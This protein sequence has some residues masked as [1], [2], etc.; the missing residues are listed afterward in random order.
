MKLAV[1]TTV[2]TLFLSMALLS[3]PM[4]IS[5]QKSTPQVNTKGTVLPTGKE[6]VSISTITGQQPQVK[7]NNSKL[8]SGKMSPTQG[9]PQKVTGTSK[10][11]APT[12]TTTAPVTTTVT[13]PAVDD[14]A[15]FWIGKDA[16]HKS[17]FEYVYNKNNTDTKTNHTKASVDEYLDLYVNFR[18]KVKEAEELGMDTIG[19]I[20][21]ELETY[22][23]QL[24][25]SY[26]FD[27][28]VN[29]KLLVEAYERMKTEVKASHILVKINE[30]GLPADTLEAWRKIMD[31][32]KKLVKGEDFATLAK[33]N[34]DDPS[35]QQNGGDIGYF[36]ALQTVYPF[37][38]VAYNTPV[39]QISMPVRTKFG[40]HLVKVT[41]SRPAQGEITVAHILIKTPKDATP[42]QLETAKKK[43][44]EAY[45]KAASGTPFEQLVAIYSEDKSTKAKNGELPPFGT[46][47]MV[48]EF[49][50]AAFGLKKD[51][52][53][54]APVKTEYGWHII[55]R[56]SKKGVASYEEA[57]SDLKK[58]IERDSRSE[59]AKQTLLDRIKKEYLFTEFPSAKTDLFKRTDS[60]LTNKFVMADKKGLDKPLFAI[61]GK[62]Y[63]QTQFAEYME[64]NQKKKRNE[65]AQKIYNDYYEKYVEES[66][67]AYEESQLE[68]KYPEF[69][70]LMK[71]YRDGILLFELTDQKVWSKAIKDTVGLAKFH[72]GNKG[73][74]MW[75]SRVD[76]EIYTVNGNEK[77]VNKI[78]KYA[79]SHTAEEVALKFNAKDPLVVKFEKG[80]YEKGQKDLV[81]RTAWKPGLG[82]TVANGDS[83]YSFVEVV[84]VVPP[85]PK[86]LNEAK[87]FIVSDYQEYLEK[88]WIADLKAKYPVKVDQQVLAS[89]IK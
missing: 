48:Q 12:N 21:S 42:E 28:E 44:D 43:I 19:S 49:E 66:L 25:K 23:K 53:F 69:K 78:K 40:Y 20:V 13:T 33:K 61:A 16:I 62:S 17:E 71:E 37:E 86:S 75:D 70:S 87:G 88:Q 65:P 5:A 36:T 26:L 76:A 81:E 11:S 83:T 68:R 3:V 72:E 79:A 45:Q 29:E 30:P 77:L 67:M 27:R 32:R 82:E 80:V 73:K 47:R 55:R 6:K 58:R 39:G 52:D 64:A 56:I 15:L 10:T 18:L 1:N 46:G 38:T 74:Y 50:T 63:T 22:R 14:P 59:I 89:L 60:T 4:A 84:K 57:K 7:S 31:I 8:P 51:G 35:A 41:D 9:Q 54:S 34:S 24:A 85:T 2:R